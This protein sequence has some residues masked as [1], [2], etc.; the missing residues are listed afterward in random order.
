M[1]LKNLCLIAKCWWWFHLLADDNENHM[2]MPVNFGS[3]IMFVFFLN[4][5]SRWFKYVCIKMWTCKISARFH[6]LTEMFPDRNGPDRNVHR[7][8]RPRP[9]RPRPKRP[10]PKRPRSKRP[11]P[12]RP[13]PKRP[14]PERLRPNRPDRKVAYPHRARQAGCM[15]AQTLRGFK[16]VHELLWHLLKIINAFIQWEVMNSK[17]NYRFCNVVKYCLW[18]RVDVSTVCIWLF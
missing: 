11:W 3:W 4:K 6:G 10:R 1:T 5:T 16:T 2:L 7:S 14:R 9:K 18:R 8:K 17:K 15:S 12:K 13:R